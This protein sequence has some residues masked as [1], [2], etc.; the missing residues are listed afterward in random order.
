MGACFAGVWELGDRFWGE[1]VEGTAFSETGWEAG[2]AEAVGLLGCWTVGNVAEGAEV[3][4]EA[5]DCRLLGVDAGADE[6]IGLL[7]CWTVGNTADEDDAGVDGFTGPSSSR[8]PA[9]SAMAPKKIG[10]SSWKMGYRGDLEMRGMGIMM[11]TF[12]S[13]NRNGCVATAG[14]ANA[15]TQRS[16]DNQDGV[17][18]TRKASYGLTYEGADL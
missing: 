13:R 9:W 4:C 8:T 5:V 11:K 7:G 6:V 12:N 16:D 17:D 2:G 15:E 10:V 14:Q 1:T 3:G 18:S